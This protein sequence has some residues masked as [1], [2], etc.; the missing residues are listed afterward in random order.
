M[1][2]LTAEE[3]VVWLGFD[4]RGSLYVVGHEGPLELKCY[5][6][7][8]TVGAG[9]PSWVVESDQHGRFREVWTTKRGAMKACSDL[10][11]KWAAE[12]QAEADKLD[13]A[14]WVEVVRAC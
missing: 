9:E 5:R 12:L 4:G 3:L 7:I 14:E 13:A 11:R 1:R 8:V 10:K 6:V 2:L